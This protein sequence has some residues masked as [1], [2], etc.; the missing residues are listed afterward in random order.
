MRTLLGGMR[1]ARRAPL[2]LAPVA[3]ESAVVALFVAT[4]A[5]PAG[6]ASA[7]AAAAFPLGLYFDLKQGLAHARGW[8]WLLAALALAVLVRGAVLA[9]T[10][11]LADDAPGPF[12]VAWGRASAL[13][14]WALLALLP[15]AALFYIGAATRY[16]PFVLAAAPLTFFPAGLVARRAAR[17]DAGAGAPGKGVPE[18]AGYLGYG[19]LVAATGA[20]LSVLGGLSPLLCA[21]AI[22]AFSPLHALFLLGWR[23]HLKAG[24]VPAA[25]TFATALTVGATVVIAA[26]VVRDRYIHNQLPSPRPGPSG[27]LLLIGGVDS[28]SA[29]GALAR[30]DPRDVGFRRQRAILLS[31]RGTGER[32]SA[33]DTRVSLAAAARVM[34]E[35]IEAARPPRAVLGHSQAGLIVDRILARRLASPDVV[36]DLAAPPPY[37]P[38]FETPPPGRDGPGRPGADIARALAG[39]MRA[40]GMRPFDID[41]PNSPTNLARVDPGRVVP[42]LSVWAL[43]DSVWL[44][45]DWRRTGSVNLIA[46]SDHVGVTNNAR[47]LRAAERFFSGERVSGDESSWR[48]MLATALRYAFAP[49]R[50]G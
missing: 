42:R 45:G 26:L 41:A 43:V 5:F 37:P 34:A 17:L 50:P 28:T 39:A 3:A 35:Q 29:S 48:S 4:G 21:L 1:A 30:L 12:A 14:G 38:P 36:V 18:F 2:A 27:S 47:A 15:G 10:L 22:V 6:A 20:V 44:E 33:L 40:L 11:W 32:Y 46:P 19:Y 23:A 8:G 24:T 31:Y 13:G 25:G 16:A 7:T 49:Y 9:G